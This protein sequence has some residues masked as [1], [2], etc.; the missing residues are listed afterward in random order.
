MSIL[1][2]VITGKHSNKRKKQQPAEN[3]K[4]IKYRNTRKMGAQFLNLACGGDS[5]PASP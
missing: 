1:K 2:P 5:H 4:N 3:L